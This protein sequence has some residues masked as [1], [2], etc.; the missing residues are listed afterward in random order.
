MSARE[1]FKVVRADGR[2]VS[3]VDPVTMRATG[4]TQSFTMNAD[5]MNEL[6]AVTASR[7]CLTHH[8]NLPCQSC[9]QAVRFADTRRRREAYLGGFGLAL[10]QMARVPKLV[11]RGRAMVSA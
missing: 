11:R 6:Q 2:Y 4:E 7:H 9:R 8:W 1:S 5:L 10:G 3:K